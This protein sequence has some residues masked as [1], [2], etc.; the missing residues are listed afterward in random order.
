MSLGL[1]HKTVSGWFE[2]SFQTPTDVQNKA[3]RAI[4]SSRNTLIA[5]PTGSGKT[6]SAFLSAI[7]DLVVQGIEGRL[8][9]GTQ[10]VY[11]SPLKALSNDIEKNLQ[12][13]LAGIKA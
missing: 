11:V 6:L 10:I 3:W 9:S 7:D 12:S 2:K 8:Q 13:P 4:K 1:F 5:A